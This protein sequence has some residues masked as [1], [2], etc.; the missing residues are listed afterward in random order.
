MLTTIFDESVRTTIINRINSL[1]ENNQRQW[2]KM[3]I[4]QMIGH[5]I[6]WNQ[7]ILGKNGLITKQSFL[8]VVFGK[9]ALRG[10]VKDNS[11]MKRNMP[12]GG[13][14]IN[15]EKDDSIEAQKKEWAD[16]IAAYADF[17]NHGFTHDF[18][19]KMSREEIGIL[20]YK[21]MDHHL[22]QFQ[23]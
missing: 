5:S 13:R 17:S 4:Y 16:L 6:F 1:S 22:R 19:G 12:A 21:H 14:F 15:K 7:W 20:A 10:M 11:P 23:A 9:M 8:G 2:G 3:N 18:F